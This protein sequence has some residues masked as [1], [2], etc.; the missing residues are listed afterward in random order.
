MSLTAIETDIENFGAL[1]LNIAAS[2][3]TVNNPNYSNVIS[4][5]TT[6]GNAAL[7][8]VGANTA[9]ATTAGATLAATVAPAISAVSVLSS[10]SAT[11]TQKASALSTIIGDAIVDVETVLSWIK[12]KTTS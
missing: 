5:A 8:A 2:L 9:T 12:P 3:T 1:A 6:L 10:K 7:A 4:Q 11:S